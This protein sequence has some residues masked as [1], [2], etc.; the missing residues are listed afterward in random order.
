MTGTSIALVTP[1]FNQRPFLAAAIESVLEQSY[2]SLQYAVVDG[3]S[4]D[5]SGEVVQSFAD[6]LAW[7]VSEKDAG[8]Y[9]AINK[10]FRQVDGEV[11]GWLNSDDLQCPWTL[12]V[13]ADV[14][15]RF[16]EVEWLT[17]RFPLRW[18]KDGRVTNCSDSRGYA[19]GAFARGE[20]CGGG[21]G[22][23]SAPIQQESTFWRRTLWDRTGGALSTEFGSAG[24]FELWCRFAK[25]AELHAVNVPLAGFRLHG[26]QQTV[27]AR[28]EYFRKAQLALEHHFP[29]QNQSPLYRRLR[30][31]ARDRLPMALHSVAKSGGLLFDAPVIFR[32][33]DNADWRIDRIPV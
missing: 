4:S 7:S 5:G 9:D 32:T 6:R 31:I 16:P 28:G 13:V 12:A 33:R 15:A 29:G 23:F 19:R 10:G 22:F 17:T 2:P 18:D 27:A 20:Y 11:M 14:F 24:D 21:T 8:Q 26:D 3:G 25:V 1:S 30:P